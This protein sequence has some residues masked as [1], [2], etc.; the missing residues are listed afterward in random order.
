VQGSRAKRIPTREFQPT[1]MGKTS[2]T[3]FMVISC[4]FFSLFFM[5]QTL[6]NCY[7]CVVML[8][9]MKDFRLF[10]AA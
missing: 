5:L 9:C 7:N 1:E 2:V 8:L 3:I 4:F 10:N 6:K